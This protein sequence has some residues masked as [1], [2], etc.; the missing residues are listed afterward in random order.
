MTRDR[1]TR[2]TL[3][4]PVDGIDEVVLADCDNNRL[5]TVRWGQPATAVSVDGCPYSVELADLDQD[6]DVDAAVLLPDADAVVLLRADGG[7][8]LGPW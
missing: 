8:N 4:T 3:R 6:G 1:V 2:G 5:V 7:G